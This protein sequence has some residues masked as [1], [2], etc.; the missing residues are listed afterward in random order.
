MNILFFLTPKAMCAY[1]DADDTIRE[2]M[3]RMEASGFTALPVLDRAG[4]YCGVLTE[5]DLLWAIKNLYLMDMRAAESHGIM[6]I[7][8]RKDNEPVSVTTP[9]EDLLSKAVDQNFVP[10]VDDKG[11]FIGIVTRKAIMQHCMEQ[12]FSKAGDQR[13]AAV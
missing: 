4:G 12:Y 9:V 3:G 10:V 6:E 13:Q 7:Q 2:A 5:G 11:A 8:H 1:V